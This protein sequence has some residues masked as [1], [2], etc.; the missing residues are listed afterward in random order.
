MFWNQFI[1]DNTISQYSIVALIILSAFILKHFFGKYAAKLFFWVMK[2]IGR[3]V[4]RLSF[5]ELI[6]GPAET[7]LFLLIAISALQTLYF[8]NEFQFKILGT[9]SKRILYGIGDT[10][11]IMTF[12]H[13]LL[14]LIDYL[15]MILE[16]RA[17][18]TPEQDDDQLV[19]FLKE[20]LKVIVW[21]VGFLILLKYV[22]GQNISQ[23]LAGLSIVGAAIALAARES[24]ENLIASFIIFFDKPFTIGDLLKVHQVQGVVEKIGL[25]S[26]RIRTL[27][28]T[29]VSVPNKQMVDSIVDNFSLRTHRRAELLLELEPDTHSEKL[30]I[31]LNAIKNI[32]KRNDLADPFVFISDFSKNAIIIN[33]EFF[34]FNIPMKEFNMI[35]QEV[36]FQIIKQMEL[37]K[38]ELKGTAPEV[39]VINKNEKN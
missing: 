2:K 13:M 29:Y 17:G 16:K 8:P 27:D 25:R 12:F 32:L 39:M 7:F 4:D 15:G 38:I 22:F 14:R 6:L 11:L 30:E 3:E 35:R 34:A 23:I 9:N 31:F 10:I 33:V 1:L 20:F 26:T 19:L 28:K 18:A 21:I 36:N 37:Q 5:L 24:I